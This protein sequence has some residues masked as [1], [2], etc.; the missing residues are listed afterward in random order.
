MARR[1]T[2][3]CKAKTKTG[4]KCC[5]L[6]TDATKYCHLHRAANAHKIAAA[7][8]KAD[9]KKR[10][11]ELALKQQQKAQKAEKQKMQRGVNALYNWLGSAA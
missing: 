11:K 1:R 5:N 8:A 7:L 9:E 3:A 2:Y 6:T 10:L 4:W